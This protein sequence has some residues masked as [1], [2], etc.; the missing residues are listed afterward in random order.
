MGAARL[1]V[2]HAADLS[3]T[4]FDI[5]QGDAALIVSPTGIKVL[6]DGGPPEGADALVAELHRR[7][8]RTIDLVILSHPHLDHLGGL[9]KVLAAVQVRNFLDSGFPSS[10]AS[11][12]ALLKDL[13]ARGVPVK[14]ATL[15][16]NIDLGDGAQLR[17]LGP[18]SPALSNTRSDV[19][20]N[21]VVA[22]LTWR[23]RTALFTGDS[24]PETERW[25]LEQNRSNP[26]VLS[27]ELLKVAHHG[28]RFSSTAPF[29]QAIKPQLAVISVAAVNDYGHPTPE[30]LARLAQT[31]ARIFRTD[32]AGH[33]TVR[34]HDGQA[35]QVESSRGS[36]AL[37]STRVTPVAPT[38][39]TREVEPVRP[40]TPVT[41]SS[42]G[43][44]GSARSDVFHRADCPAAR[45]IVPGNQLRFA[46]REA[47]VASNRR[48]AADCR[49]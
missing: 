20:A 13:A 4:F 15:G 39:A 29:L 14:Q 48:P 8:V 32:Q 24:E 45:Q 42:G 22:R 40:S 27:A 49:P 16:R 26:A 31:G 47:A 23:G 36:P 11:Y 18:P 41:A 35:W 3:L 7:D 34:S 46:T 33:V 37:S 21:S 1:P 17:L 6:V 38:P 30:A 44:V 12:V 28:G 5:G 9:R 43:Y 25:L 2:A 10:S 19:N